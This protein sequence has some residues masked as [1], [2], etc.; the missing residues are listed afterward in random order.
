MISGEEHMLL[1]LIQNGVRKQRTSLFFI[2]LC[3]TWKQRIEEEYNFLKILTRQN[4]AWRYEVK[5]RNQNNSSDSLL[6][7]RTRFK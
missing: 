2:T 4:L 6:F 3:L 7:L 1:V 5:L